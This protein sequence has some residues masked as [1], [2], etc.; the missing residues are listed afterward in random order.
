MKIY[1]RIKTSSKSKKAFLA[2]FI[3]KMPATYVDE[4]RTMV[5]FRKGAAR[6]FKALYYICKTKFKT[7]TKKEVATILDSL[8]RECKVGILAC[9]DIKKLTFFDLKKKPT[10]WSFYDRKTGELR[11]AYLRDQ[12]NYAETNNSFEDFLKILNK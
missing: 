10:W 9:P 12:K 2:D 3:S 11:G 6:T 8:A 4:K 7:T 5:E 1:V